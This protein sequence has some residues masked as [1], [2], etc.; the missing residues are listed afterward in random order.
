[1]CSTHRVQCAIVLTRLPYVDRALPDIVIEGIAARQ[2]L[3][4]LQLDANPLG[5]DSLPAN[6][7]LDGL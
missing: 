3:D 2:H 6:A 5:F 7:Y 1:M 4:L